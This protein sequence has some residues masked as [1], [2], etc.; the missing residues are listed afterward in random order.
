MIGRREHHGAGLQVFRRCSGVICGRRCSLRHRYV[1]GFLDEARELLVGDLGGVHPESIDGHAMDGRESVVACIPTTS[2]ASI[3]E[4][5]PIE[6]SPPGIHTIPSGAGQA[7][8]SLFSTVSTNSSEAGA[9]I[10]GVD[11]SGIGGLARM[12]LN[13]IPTPPA[14]TMTMPGSIHLLAVACSLK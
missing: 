13:A 12:R 2:L 14:S 7:L 9:T 11:A 6:N 5:A 1:L 3:G 8:G 4:R 10:I